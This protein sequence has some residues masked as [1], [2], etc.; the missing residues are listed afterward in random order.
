VDLGALRP[1]ADR[2][3]VEAAARRHSAPAR[4]DAPQELAAA[5]A[6][7]IAAHAEPAAGFARVV[8]A[9]ASCQYEIVV[10]FSCKVQGLCPSLPVVIALPLQK[11][12]REHGNTELLDD[13]L[14][15]FHG[16]QQ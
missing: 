12:A 15:P 13:D 1:L 9:C 5:R 7:S 16:E 11:D 4:C 2:S 10:P 6:R 14:V 8:C 3:G